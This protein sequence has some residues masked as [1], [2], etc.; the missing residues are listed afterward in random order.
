MTRDISGCLNRYES[1]GVVFEYPDFWELSEQREPEG[2]VVVTVAADG[3]CFW[4]LRILFTSPPP[5]EV[6]SSCVS[7]F[8]EEYDDVEELTLPQS[9]AEMPAY[10]RELNFTCFELINT[11]VLS[12]VRTL[13]FTLLVWWQGTDHE[14]GEARELLEHI[15]NSLRVVSLL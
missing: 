12:S 14:L 9:L 1:H 2:D 4:T 15:T 10:C 3:T 13:E 6:V 8:R 11:V 5:P 7:A